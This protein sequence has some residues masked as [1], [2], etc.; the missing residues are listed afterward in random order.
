MRGPTHQR[1]ALPEWRAEPGRNE[2]RPGWRNPASWPI[3]LYLLGTGKQDLGCIG[4]YELAITLVR[5]EASDEEDVLMGH[6]PC[7]KGQH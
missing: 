3:Q 4:Q 7:G 1:P 6:L 5:G 2:I